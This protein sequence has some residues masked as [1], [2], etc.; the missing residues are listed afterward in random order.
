MK[1]KAKYYVQI[2]IPVYE[3]TPKDPCLLSET[4]EEAL[5][6][7]NQARLLQPENKY[8]INLIDI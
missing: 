6:E 5:A 7:L 1:K 8:Q 4:Y 3:K 2:W